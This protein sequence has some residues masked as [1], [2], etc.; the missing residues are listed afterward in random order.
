[1][2]IDLF[3]YHW[4]VVKKQW[5][6]YGL[7]MG[8][9][10]VGLAI[11]ALTIWPPSDIN[12]P[13]GSFKG[14]HYWEILL[15]LETIWN[16]F[17]P[18]PAHLPEFRQTNVLDLVTNVKLRTLLRVLLAM[19]I[20][21]FAVVPLFK[22]RL[23]LLGWVAV[24]LGMLYIMITTYTGS[25]RHQGY[26]ALSA[27]LFIWVQ[28]QFT[29]YRPNRPALSLTWLLPGWRNWSLP[30]ARRLVAVLL[31]MQVA[32]G[33]VC[34]AA[35]LFYPFSTRTET[36]SYIQSGPLRNWFRAGYPSDIAE[37]IASGLPDHRMYYP[38]NSQYGGFLRY[39]KF[40]HRLNLKQVI[41]SL[42]HTNRRPALLILN[43]SIEPDSASYFHL[44]PIKSFTG[45][46]QP[47]EN[48]YLY[49]YQGSSAEKPINQRSVTQRY[50]APH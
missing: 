15:R 23:A 45:S 36:I 18:I 10:G 7:S 33:V 2:L 42:H 6:W 9:V 25:L 5:L 24:C 35:D 39:D 4:P 48:Y 46:I 37:H 44:I 8:I 20:I 27:L 29:D 50:H 47:D 3:L 14:W 34:Y 40:A 31:L 16:V 17:V 49:K 21:G 12:L 13:P 30:L 28:R 26:F 22:S 43:R 38:G 32:G 41:D 11:G 19:G 1:M